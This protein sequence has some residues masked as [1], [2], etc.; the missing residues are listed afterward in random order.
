[1]RG[2]YPN[3]PTGNRRDREL[4]LRARRIQK[5]AAWCAARCGTTSACAENTLI[6][7]PLNRPPG[8]YLRVRGEYPLTISPVLRNSE[9]PP[10]ARRI[11]GAPLRMAGEAGTT[12]ACAENTAR[13]GMNNIHVRNYLR[14]RGEYTSRNA[15]IQLG[16][17]LPPR[18]RRIPEVAADPRS[19]VGTTSACAENTAFIVAGDGGGWNYLRV[20]GEY[21]WW[22]L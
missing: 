22:G 1:M 19:L 7:P 15:T 14:V 18:A 17:E 4:P 12:S 21:L 3:T 16:R 13:G 5:G 6:L 2:E 20:R 11:R 9:L 8:N 10:R